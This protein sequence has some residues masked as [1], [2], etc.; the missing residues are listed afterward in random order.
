MT[1]QLRDFVS[2]YRPPRQ[3]EPF[4][5]FFKEEPK[6]KKPRRKSLFAAKK[7]RQNQVLPV[8]LIVD[9]K[10]FEKFYGRKSKPGTNK[11]WNYQEKIIH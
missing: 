1:S 6:P 10:R 7:A 9:K 11:T 8:P 3:S 4:F 5:G 2:T